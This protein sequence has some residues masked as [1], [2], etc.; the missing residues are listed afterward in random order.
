MRATIS[1]FSPV[2]HRLG[3]REAGNVTVETRRWAGLDS[4]VAR[5]VAKVSEANLRAYAAQPL[6]VR[7]HAQ[8]EL[9][10]A[11]GGYGRRQIYELIQNGADELID[12]GHGRIQILL[13]GDHL[14]CANEGDALDVDGVESLLTSHI[15]MK[16]SSE[17]GR[18]GLG[19][20]SVLGVSDRPE[21]FSATGSF[22]FDPLIA[23]AR[24]REVVP[25]AQTT[26]AL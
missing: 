13:T 7:E 11:Q 6:L 8:I 4:E 14:Y 26:P 5:H 21:V 24:I 1:G 20:K 23:Q 16:R 9:H 17:I 15:S 3:C 12:V 2:L 10:T 18:F 19:F 25:D 22:K